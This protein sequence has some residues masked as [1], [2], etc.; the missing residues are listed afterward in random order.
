MVAQGL[1]RIL[2]KKVLVAGDFMLDRYTFG[3]STRISPEAPVPVVTV[4]REEERAG[5]AGNVALNL[6]SLGMKAQVLGRVGDDA[7]ARALL[8]SLADEGVDTSW[9]ISEAGYTTPQKVRLIA[10][11]QQ[12]ARIDYEKI[13]PLGASYEDELIAQIPEMLQNVSCVAISD[14]GKGFLTVRLLRAL[15]DQARRN[16]I[17]VIADPKGKD[18]TKYSR[19]TCLKPNLSEARAAM[20]LC[21]TL[22]DAAQ[23]IL[24]NTQ[25]DVLMVTKS[26]EGISLFYPDGKEDLFP[27]EAKEVKDVTGA[28]DTVLAMLA[29]AYSNDI[30]IREG[31]QLANIAAQVA[32]QRIGC[33]RVSLSEVRDSSGR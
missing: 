19:A 24:Q 14:Y 16:N 10:S 21:D 22:R 2:P 15:I 12:V 28:G 4:D 1:G 17:P 32:V 31:A 23:Q 7:A 20:P 5:G 29:A 26:E 6:I 3:K 8:S 13:T 18:F 11:N 27:V 30:P 25:V 9:L 33:A